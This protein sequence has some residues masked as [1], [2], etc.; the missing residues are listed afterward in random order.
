MDGGDADDGVWFEVSDDGE[1]WEPVVHVPADSSV[2]ASFDIGQRGGTVHVRV[3]DSDR[4]IGQQGD[5]RVEIDVLHLTADGVA[6]RIA[7]PSSVSVAI[8]ASTQGGE[9]GRQFGV[10]TAV[11]LDDRGG[12]V[13]GALVRIRLGG[14]FDEEVEGTTAEDGSVTVISTASER[15]PTVAACVLSVDTELTYLPGDEAC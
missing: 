3:V 13:A 5:D 9:L 12:A 14:S 10:A 15:K 2:A 8:A 1:R 4:S 7:G 11:V 6:L